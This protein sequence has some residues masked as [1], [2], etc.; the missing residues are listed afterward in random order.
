MQPP[1]LLEVRLDSKLA[2]KVISG[3]ITSN[4]DHESEIPRSMMKHNEVES[5]MAYCYLAETFRVE[6]PAAAV[7]YHQQV[8]SDPIPDCLA[9]VSLDH[10]NKLFLVV[11]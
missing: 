1:E 9:W 7:T 2:E 4:E 5:R 10:Q 11:A 8:W 6:I 3:L